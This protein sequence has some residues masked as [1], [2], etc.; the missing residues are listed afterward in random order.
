MSKISLD[1]SSIKSAGV[2]TIEIDES[3]R[4]ETQVN[5]LRLL[6]GFSGKGP[7][8]RPVFLQTDAQ[9]QKLFGDIDSKLEKKGCFFNRAAKTMLANGPIL[10]LNL[11]KVDD[12]FE[13][14]D[15]VNYAALSLD[16]GKKNPVVKDP[17]VTYGEVDYLAETVDKKI[18]GTKTGATIPFV[19]KAPYSALFDRSRFWTPSDT[20]LMNVASIGLGTGGNGSYESSNFINFANIGTDEI[21]L[22][23]FKP[24]GYNGY[25]VTAKDWYGGEENIPYGWIRPSDYMSDYFI[26]VVAVKGNWS[27]YP[28]LSAD[29]T[30]GKYF[31]SKGILKDKIYQFSQAEGITFVGSWT[32][33][34]IPD[35]TDKQG[36]YLYIKERVN[37]YTEST[38]VLMSINEDA[39]QI[40][41][42]DKNGIDLATG[43]TTGQ[44]SW[45]YDYDGNGEA[46]SDAGETEIGSNGFLIDMVGHGFHYGVRSDVSTS[47][48]T[49]SFASVIFDGSAGTL[50]TNSSVWYLDESDEYKDISGLSFA[51]T[52]K[53]PVFAEKPVVNA[54]DKGDALHLYGVY[55][56]SVGRRIDND[57]CYVALSEKK[58]KEISA[59]PKV[60]IA[61]FTVYTADGDASTATV[62]SVAGTKVKLTLKDD[63]SKLKGDNTLYRDDPVL[64][65]SY[66]AYNNDTSSLYIFNVQ[67]G[68]NGS[69][70]S[71]NYALFDAAN[72]DVA[73]WKIGDTSTDVREFTYNATS[74]AFV[75]G[76]TP[77]FYVQKEIG[78]PSIYGVNFLSYNYVSETSEEVLK[79]IRN[80]YYFNGKTNNAHSDLEPVDLIDT[81]LF[82]G[83]NPTTD[84]A[85]NT[86]IITDENEAA[87][88]AVGDL[89]ENI[90][91]NNNLGEATKFGLIPGVTR[92]AKKIFVNL[93]ADN[94]FTYGG[95]KYSFNTSVAAPIRTK[96]GRRGFY[97]FTALEPVLIDK[98][99]RI[100]RQLPLSSDVISKSLRFIPLKGLQISSRHRPGFD[101]NGRI[102]INDGI[103]KIY[104]VLEDEGI[105]RGLCNTNMVS[106]RYIVDSMSYGIDDELGGKAYLSRLASNRGKCTALI[107]APS[108]HQFE[109]SSDPVFCATYDA[110]QYVKPAFNTKYLASGG[111]PDMFATRGF[112]LPGKGVD[113]ESKYTAC[114]YPHLIY[115]ENGH[116]IIVPPAAD[117]SNTFVRKFQGGDPYAITANMDGLIKNSTAKIVRPECDVD[118]EDRGYLEQIGINAIIREGNEIKIYSNKTA[119]QSIKSDFNLLSSRENLNTMELAIDDVLK[120]FNFKYNT[121]QSRAAIITAVTP[122]MEAMKL[123]KALD[124]Y[125]LICDE[126]N[127]TEEIILSDFGI[128]DVAVYLNHGLEKLVTRVRVRKHSDIPTA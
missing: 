128:L 61:K 2:Y 26:R 14:P 116:E 106:Y 127:N 60:D 18:Y 124:Y 17:G 15:Q 71:E 4:T 41:S 46:D 93:T 104:S 33:S 77:K 12:S 3:T 42:Y 65:G 39:M 108:K 119:Y 81:N 48:L 10:A 125:E 16:A 29:K 75:P 72:L 49:N 47:A 90:A 105:Q 82:F 73:T 99:H 36:N 87:D 32:G 52:V 40:I 121:P 91:F 27:N 44:G 88:I 8:N 96:S 70:V 64:F 54:Y 102:S 84:D 9:R 55:D 5:A 107:N 23:V 24:E 25:D 98:N 111:N 89:V 92:I 118:A 56:A 19:G 28:I 122:I 67:S 101:E 114:F 59:N 83:E 110:E 13:G 117:V 34:I 21:S 86:F 109:V 123:S 37:A 78:A 1:L 43:E 115:K 74:Y 80:A 103:K 31:D 112:S 126:T 76:T 50:A 95:Q 35:F 69:E 113:D 120:T 30:W 11:L 45:I 100:T 63:L 53:T 6:V 85:L 20:N 38:G 97:L 62:S 22:L 58:F 51:T 68:N 66:A 57:Y 94:K 79:N 7:F